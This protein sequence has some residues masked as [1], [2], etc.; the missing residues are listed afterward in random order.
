MVGAEDLHLDAHITQVLKAEKEDKKANASLEAK[1]DQL[2]T[3]S[4]VTLAESC[5]RPQAV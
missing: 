2:I 3:S 4:G 1:Q 5:H